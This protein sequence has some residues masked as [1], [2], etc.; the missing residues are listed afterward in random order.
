MSQSSSQIVSALFRTLQLSPRGSLPGKFPL[1]LTRQNWQFIAANASR[2]CVA[3]KTDG[4]RMTIWLRP[5]AGLWGFDR[6]LRPLL[7]ARSEINEELV[8]DCERCNSRLVVFDLLYCK[9]KI[10]AVTMPYLERLQLADSRLEMVR[11]VLKCAEGGPA[12]IS[13]IT[14]K[15]VY[16]VANIETAVGQLVSESIQSE[17]PSDGL[18]FTPQLDLPG[19]GVFKWKSPGGHTVD[20][21]LRPPFFDHRGLLISHCLAY[22][23]ESGALQSV[24]FQYLQITRAEHSLFRDIC[25]SGGSCVVEAG[26]KNG[27]WHLLKVRADKSKP[28]FLHVIVNC[29]EA[30]ADHIQLRDL[31]VPPCYQQVKSDQI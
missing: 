31:V 30:E 6:T 10:D 13:E 29:L 12:R 5:G 18:V 15:N 11:G 2:Y 26:W 23:S 16:P 8:L 7:L 9:G 17:I 20:L 28:N 21:G 25:Q 3:N 19:F 22:D 1:S 24:I 14:I 4:E 27:R